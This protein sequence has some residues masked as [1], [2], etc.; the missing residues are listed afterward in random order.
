MQ[1]KRECYAEQHPPVSILQLEIH[2]SLFCHA[3]QPGTS[4]QIVLIIVS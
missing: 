2:D 1:Q 3:N 4:G